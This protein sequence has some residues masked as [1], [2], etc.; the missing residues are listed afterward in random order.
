MFP[1]FK[2]T[3]TKANLYLLYFI[4]VAPP[5]VTLTCQLTEYTIIVVLIEEAEFVFIYRLLLLGT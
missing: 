5:R 3:D 4:S 2:L 1:L